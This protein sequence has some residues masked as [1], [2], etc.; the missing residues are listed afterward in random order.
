M[1][2]KK[3][4]VV[5]VVLAVILLLI[6]L[7]IIRSLNQE[8]E[9]LG[10]YPNADCQKIE[11]S[12]SIT[13]FAFGAF[14][15][16]FALGFYLLFFSKGEDA[17]VRRLEQD[18]Q[19]KLGEE[20]LS[21]LLKGLDEFEKKAFLAVKE[22]DG[23]TQNTLRLRVDM[24]KAKLSQVLSGLEKKNLIRREPQGKSLAIYVKERV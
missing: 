11:T 14:G 19:R 12:L 1:D 15:F 9:A 16:L 2:N 13:H 7:F 10:C 8:I 17:I 21:I 5:L 18:T 4:G 23:I 3:V 6:F 20:K 22:Q 24:S